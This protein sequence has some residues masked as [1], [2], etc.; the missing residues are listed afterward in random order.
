MRVAFLSRKDTRFYLKGMTVT[1]TI[2]ERCFKGENPES[3][4]MLWRMRIRE[5]RAGV[6]EEDD[7]KNTETINER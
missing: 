1:E 6:M 5:K 7:R 2:T 3:F 4:E